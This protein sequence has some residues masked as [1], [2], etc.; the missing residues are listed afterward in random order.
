MAISLMTLTKTK[1]NRKNLFDYLTT[2]AVFH[3]GLH[4]IFLVLLKTGWLI[5]IWSSILG[6]IIC[7][8]IGFLK[9]EKNSTKNHFILSS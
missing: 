3:F 1:T 4:I 8:W 6:E 2:D 9:K 5:R 7:F